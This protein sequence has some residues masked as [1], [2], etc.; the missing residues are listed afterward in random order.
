L[1]EAERQH[2]DFMSKVS[3]DLRS[4]L[5]AILGYAELMADE[6]LRHK[7]D[8]LV[9]TQSVI[10]QQGYY[11]SHFIE[12]VLSAIETE[13]NLYPMRMSSFHVVPLIEDVLKDIKKKT[14][15]TIVFQNGAGD[16]I[17]EADGLGL[18]EVLVRLVD[19][20]LKFSGPQEPVHVGLLP[21]G[22]PGWIDIPVRD[23]G[24]GIDPAEIPTLFRRFSRVKNGA[25]RDIPGVGLGLYIVGNIVRHHQGRITVE[26]EPGA[27][28]KFTVSLPLTQNGKSNGPG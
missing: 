11:I 6:D 1:E 12:D 25:N 19:N 20:G 18:R 8:F 27:G 5:A 23:S 10:T 7:E 28:S 2:L 24:I 17:L 4:P 21:G 26:S 3:H 14:G 13:A 9:R 15:R 16:V 22:E